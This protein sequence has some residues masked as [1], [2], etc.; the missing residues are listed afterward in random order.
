MTVKQ[1]E[2]FLGDIRDDLSNLDKILIPEV[3]NIVQDLKRDAPRAK[4]DGGA[5][6]DSIQGIISGDNVQFTMLAYGIYQNYGVDGTK[7]SAGAEPI[8][9]GVTGAGYTMSFGTKT[10]G[11]DLP[12]KVRKKIA[13]FGLKPKN[14]FSMKDITDQLVLAI[15]NNTQP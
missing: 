14:W 11:G 13:E 12:F 5:L 9:D 7:K 2:E 1:F 4:K 10:I 6:E 15:E 8:K 3:N